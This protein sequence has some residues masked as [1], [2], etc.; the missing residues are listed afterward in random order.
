VANTA[1]PEL[2]A[3]FLSGGQS[4]VRERQSKA[5]VKTKDILWL[6]VTVIDIQRMAVIDRIKE[7]EENM[8]D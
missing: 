5:C 8:F 3:D 4:K 6:E 2:L 7:L 1:D